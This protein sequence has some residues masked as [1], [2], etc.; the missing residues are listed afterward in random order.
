VNRAVFL[1]RD[2]VINA[3]AGFVH[4]MEDVK[5]YPDAVEALTKLSAS[6]CRVIVVTNQ[7]GIGRGYY[8]EDEYKAF[9]SDYLQCLQTLSS[10][11]ISIDKVYHCP[12]HPTAG[13]GEYRIVCECRK[14]APGMLRQAEKEFSLSLTRSYIIGDKRS[15]IVAGQAV[16][17]HGS[18]V[19][20]GCAGEGGDFDEPVIP[21]HIAE[22]VG[23]AVNEILRLISQTGDSV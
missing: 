6:S 13:I 7:P 15:D 22:T 3:D 10:G 12:H 18:L 8:S 11:K 1:D 23:D 17:C 16:G 21:D 9:E 5:F 14:P 4:R 20:T 19:K 2:G